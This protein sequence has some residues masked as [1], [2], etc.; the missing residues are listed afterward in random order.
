MC[1]G[2]CKLKFKFKLKWFKIR[3]PIDIR[4]RVND[5]YL[6]NG[7][8][9]GRI[10]KI[11][12]APRQ[13]WFFFNY[14]DR[15]CTELVVKRKH[16][17]CQLQNYHFQVENFTMVGI[18][19]VVFQIAYCLYLYFNKVYIIFFYWLL[20]TCYLFVLTHQ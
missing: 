7:N 1:N 15:V 6:K 8:F 12:S 3:K 10:T 19:Y 20:K 5:I 13:W 4:L 18:V 17:L 2:F 16:F 14:F 11:P 9:P